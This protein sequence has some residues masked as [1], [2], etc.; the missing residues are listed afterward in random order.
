MNHA[1]FS[2][3]FLIALVGVSAIVFLLIG[4]F[5]T[6]LE[7]DLRNE[8]SLPDTD[9]LTIISHSTN[10]RERV[11]GMIFDGG[12]YRLFVA[13]RRFLEAPL[14]TQDK[15]WVP[16]VAPAREDGTLLLPETK[17]TAEFSKRFPEK[18]TETEIGKFR[19]LF[20]RP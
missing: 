17:D 3:R 9:A 7:L 10:G 6:Q 16:R 4:P 2:L 20:D 1:R 5:Q 8:L 14:M 18:P 11:T 19:E 13:Y 12:S 15:W